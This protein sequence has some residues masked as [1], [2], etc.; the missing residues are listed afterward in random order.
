[1]NEKS[2]MLTEEEGSVL[3]Q[4]LDVAVKAE[5][6]KHAQ[7]ALVLTSKVQQAFTEEPKVEKLE[8]P[9]KKKG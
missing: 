1:M 7:N 8:V 6:L 9:K 2:V 3:I 4:L 5:G